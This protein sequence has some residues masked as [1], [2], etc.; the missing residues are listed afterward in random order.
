MVVGKDSKFVPNIDNFLDL[1]TAVKNS[2]DQ[3][4]LR[5]IAKKG[6]EYVR[7]DA[8]ESLEDTP[9]NQRILEEIVEDWKDWRNWREDESGVER[10]TEAVESA[11][12]KVN[13]QSLLEEVAQSEIYTSKAR[14]IAFSKIESQPFLRERAVEDKDW[15]I[16]AYAVKNLEKTPENQEFLK[17]RAKK[18][19]NGIVSIEIDERL[20]KLTAPTQS[21]AAVISPKLAFNP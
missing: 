8:I 2:E 21:K 7:P 6:D 18:E 14:E 16:R 4:F 11:V 12:K 9:E 1:K 20:E 5:R 13:K 15:N 17:K 19:K 3:D 10:T